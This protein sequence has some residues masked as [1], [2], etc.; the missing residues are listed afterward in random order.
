MPKRASTRKMSETARRWTKRAAAFIVAL[1]AVAGAITA[2]K[3]LWPAPDPPDS[4][5]RAQ[6]SIR[7]I[8]QVRLSD[9]AQRLAPTEAQGFRRAQP[10]ETVGPTADTTV[11]PTEDTTGNTTDVPPTTTDSTVTSP[12][13]SE[14]TGAQVELRRQL[15]PT[16]V[17]AVADEVARRLGYCQ[18]SKGH[19]CADEL[20]AFRRMA[21]QQGYPT[22][23]NGKEVDPQVAAERVLK[24]LEDSRQTAQHEPIGAVVT[25]DAVLVGLRDRPVLLAWA[26]WHA[27]GGQRLH[28]GWFNK[29]LAYQLLAT[30]DHDSATVQLWVPLPTMPGPYLIDVEATLDGSGLA[31]GRSDPFE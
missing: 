15:D 5:D 17:D 18:S 22:D 20:P 30:T 25:V 8:S 7:V 9:Y 24:V 19:G 16:E 28:A 3:A 14:S 6:L 12:P 4:E 21:I 31:S 27:T 1:G 26:M 10:T 13:A 23:E 11:E 2:L 29:H